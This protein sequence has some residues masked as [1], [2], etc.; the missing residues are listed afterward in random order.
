MGTLP[1]ASPV[2]GREVDNGEIAWQEK[3]FA[4][5]TWCWGTLGE[6][7]RLK[8]CCQSVAVLSIGKEVYS[9]DV[10][11]RMG[12]SNIYPPDD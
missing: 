8:L 5:F 11:V 1:P 6:I 12:P 3:K 4:V 9:F 2:C 10:P 7:V